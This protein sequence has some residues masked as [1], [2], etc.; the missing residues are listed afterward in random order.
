MTSRTWVLSEMAATKIFFLRQ[1]IKR[2]IQDL[3]L[4]KTKFDETEPSIR[5]KS[6]KNF[7]LAKDSTN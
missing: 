2:S 7:L 3:I 4:K 5:G 1:Q 6:S